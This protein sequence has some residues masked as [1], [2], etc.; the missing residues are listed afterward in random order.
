MITLLLGWGWGV[1]GL[2]EGGPSLVQFNG[3]PLGGANFQY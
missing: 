2:G 1:G 3:R